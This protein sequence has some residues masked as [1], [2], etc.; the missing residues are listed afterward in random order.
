MEDKEDKIII[1]LNI[2]KLN[3]QIKENEKNNKII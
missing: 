1:K 3:E 2:N